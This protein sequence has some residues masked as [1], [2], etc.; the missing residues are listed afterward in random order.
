M[1]DEMKQDVVEQTIAKQ[2]GKMVQVVYFLYLASLVL[3][4]TGLIGVIIAYMNKGD[5]PEWAKSHFQYQIRTFWIG[6]LGSLIGGVT[7]AIGIGLLI[8]LAVVVWMIIRCV[9][10]LKAYGAEAP[11]ENPT[12]WVW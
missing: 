10:G 5:A 2:S 9:K 7:M 1:S 12:T 6:I 3:G 4:I 8:I 11:I